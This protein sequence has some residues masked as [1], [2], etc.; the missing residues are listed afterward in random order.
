MTNAEACRQVG[1]NI[2]TGRRWGYGRHVRVNG[3]GYT[4][5]PIAAGPPVISPRFLSEN[6]RLH[7]ADLHRSGMSVRALGAKLGRAPSTISRE[8][9]RNADPVSGA[10]HPYAAHRRAAAPE[11]HVMAFTAAFNHNFHASGTGIYPLSARPFCPAPMVLCRN[12]FTAAPTCG[13]GYFE[14]T[15]S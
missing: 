4:Y 11:I 5:G 2:R 7:I 1:I 14:Q 6:E 15:I 9:R 13:S 8:L 10:Y 3:R 12:A